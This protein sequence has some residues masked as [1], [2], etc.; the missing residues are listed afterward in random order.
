MYL[1]WKPKVEQESHYSTES[2]YHSGHENDNSQGNR[3][4]ENTN[5][6]SWRYGDDIYGDRDQWEANSSIEFYEF[7]GWS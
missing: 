7:L 5:T 2:E 6:R 4:D 1:T 3:R